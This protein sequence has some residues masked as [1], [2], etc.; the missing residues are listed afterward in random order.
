VLAQTGHLADARD[1]FAE[2]LTLDPSNPEAKQNFEQAQQMLSQANKS[3][4]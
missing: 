4:N 2:A 1:Q 3:H